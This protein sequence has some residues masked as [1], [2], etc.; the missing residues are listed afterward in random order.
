[1]MEVFYFSNPGQEWDLKQTNKN[2]LSMVLRNIYL[3]S[4][5]S[6]PTVLKHGAHAGVQRRTDNETFLTFSTW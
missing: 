6:A 3:S 1:M 2:T 4:L 5:Q